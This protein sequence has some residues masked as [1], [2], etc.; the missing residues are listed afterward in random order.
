M[1]GKFLQTTAEKKMALIVAI[2]ENSEDMAKAAEAGGADAVKV[3]INVTH[4][5]SGVTFGSL[6]QER[7]ALER[8]LKSVS[9]PVGIVPGAENGV[10]S[11]EIEEIKTMG[12]DF[13][14]MFV[15]YYPAWLMNV[16]GITRIAAID[17]SCDWEFIR[18][19]NNTP[20]EAFEGA[21]I[22]KEQ[23]GQGLTLSDINRYSM[24]TSLLKKPIIIPSQKRLHPE[25]V[26]L[27]AQA[28]SKSIMIGVLST[29]STF[30]ELE[31]ATLA[32]S[33]AISSL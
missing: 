20:I 24:L 11:R 7:P 10:S 4:R 28:G 16:Q 3:H 14:D 25:E 15:H 6:S 31:K 32:F 17:S 29:G 19:L 30:K 13:L 9:I 2:P 26:H 21:I 22:P 27:L 33:K 12:F 1:A 8:I 18:G 23:Y 5:A